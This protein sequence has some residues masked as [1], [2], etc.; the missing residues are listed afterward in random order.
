MKTKF[1]ILAILLTFHFQLL[2]FNCFSQNWLWAKNA[3]GYTYFADYGQFI[4]KDNNGNVYVAGLMSMPT[5]SF[6]TNTFTIN[7]FNDLF[8]AKYDTSGNELWAKQ[9][10]GYNTM[11]SGSAKFEG[12]GDL[13]FDANTNS[14][15]MTG[16]FVG[17]CVFGSFTLNN[18]GSND[19][20]AFIAKFDLNGNCTWAKSAGGSGD[21]VFGPLTVASDGSIYVTGGTPNGG[22]IG[23]I[24]VPQG[25]LIAKYDNNG[26]CIWAK[27]TVGY[28]AGGTSIKTYNSD[29]LILGFNAM[30]SFYVDTMQIQTNNYRGYFLARF[31][32]TGSVLQVNTYIGGP[33]AIGNGD[34]SLDENGN[35]YIIGNFKNGFATFNN[36]ID[37]IHSSDSTH[38]FLAKYDANGN[39][40]WV[41]QDSAS[42]IAGG[43]SV[44]ADTENNIYITGA[45]SGSAR[46]GSFNVTASTS[47]DMFVA[48]YN[49]AGVCI[50]V[51]TA[52]NAFGGTVTADVG[53]SCYVTGGFKES[54]NF[55]S[56]I[57]TSLAGDN[58]N[59]F[60]A[61]SNMITG[62][63]EVHKT[64]N[65]NLLIYANPTTSRCNITVPDEFL[66]ET[67]LTLSIFDNAG[68]LI[69]QQKLE[70]SENKIKLDL[71]AEA[72]GIYTA[73]LSNGKK[74]YTGKIVFE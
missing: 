63:S 69:Q 27:I 25:N 7:G 67:N 64:A 19:V 26:N 65:N 53:G 37:T 28:S 68:K 66:N 47:S 8:L 1:L 51:N 36:N 12:A 34:M 52:G 55:G 2:T 9:F 72:K 10:G 44:F 57:L 40:K 71:E 5:C 74:S 46:F 50:G 20:Q 58:Y 14:L 31:D 60:T 18:A 56:T 11:V 17:S 43:S 15:Y 22:I 21:D 38:F 70:M 33:S 29:I 41:Q 3:G 42:L 4:C 16:W 61:K 59:I 54:S 13:V 35:C 45:F 23:T 32:T 6:S 39:F 30:D 24:S 48:K 73:V 49:A 62:I